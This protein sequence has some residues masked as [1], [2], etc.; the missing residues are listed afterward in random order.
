MKRA[1]DDRR[2]DGGEYVTELAA[3]LREPTMR[4]CLRAIQNDCLTDDI[5]FTEDSKAISPKFSAHIQFRFKS[6]ARECVEYI[7]ACA[8]I[9]WY[10]ERVGGELVPRT[11]PFGSFTWQAQYKQPWELAQGA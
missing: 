5:V 2:V 4:H 7:H 11:L 8:F 3:F 1:R 6:F 10:L 9:P